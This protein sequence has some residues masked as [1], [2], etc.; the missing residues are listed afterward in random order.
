[1][2][3]LVS[4]IPGHADAMFLNSYAILLELMRS[5]TQVS[6]LCAVFTVGT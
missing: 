5:F 6:V 1:M 2:L 3:H 4:E